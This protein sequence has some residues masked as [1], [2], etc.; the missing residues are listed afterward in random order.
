MDTTN[1]DKLINNDEFHLDTEGNSDVVQFKPAIQ[2][3][4][5]LNT[6]A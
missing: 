4:S 5:L 3:Q 2:Y 6:S 1:K